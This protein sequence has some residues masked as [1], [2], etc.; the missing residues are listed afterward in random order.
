M[1][2]AK[3]CLFTL[4]FDQRYL[5]KKSIIN[6]SGIFF[7]EHTVVDNIAQPP[8]TTKLPPVQPK[9]V[10]MEITSQVTTT[11]AAVAD[12]GTISKVISS[13]KS[14]SALLV[15]IFFIVIAVAA[16]LWLGGYQRIRRLLSSDHS[17][18]RKVDDDDPEK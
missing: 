5:F 6:T 9:P 14:S 11:K 15:I 10:E 17:K 7:Q 13:P 18:Y 1:L 3:R 2:M 8:T 16:F 4:S 12:A